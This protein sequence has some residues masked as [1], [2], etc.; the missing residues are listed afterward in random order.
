MTTVNRH[1]GEGTLQ[2]LLDGELSPFERAAAETHLGTCP[3][4]ADELR[5]LRELNERATGLLARMDVPAPVAQAQ[6]RMRARRVH[7]AAPRAGV[8][9]QALLRAA[10]LVLGVT[11]VAAA[12]VPGSPVREWI[13]ENVLP[14]PK[15]AAAPTL[16]P[17]PPAPQPEEPDDNEVL[18]VSFRPDAS[19]RVVLTGA[20]PDLEIVARLVDG[21]SARAMVHGPNKSAQ[22]SMATGRIEVRLTKDARSVEIL[23]PRGI[24][25]ANV[26]VNGRVYV[27]KQGESLVLLPPATAGS[28]PSVRVGG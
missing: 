3:A 26:E 17:A 22:F 12:A 4:C 27:S 18:G 6:M 9:R 5:E 16:R 19:V 14:K 23:L 28:G 25:R 10:L 21:E 2:A 20:T 1:L 24:N 11:G 15:E 7:T 13:V 8:W